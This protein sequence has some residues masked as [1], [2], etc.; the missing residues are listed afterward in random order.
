MTAPFD[1]AALGIAGSVAN[2]LLRAGFTRNQ[3][4]QVVIE[5]PADIWDQ[6]IREE[7][8]LTSARGVKFRR[9]PK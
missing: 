6:L 7:N 2:K 9:I 8:F 3:V 5:L 4:A 1:N